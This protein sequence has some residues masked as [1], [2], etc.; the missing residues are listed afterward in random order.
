MVLFRR[1]SV[2]ITIGLLILAFNTVHAKKKA[3]IIAINRYAPTSGWPDTHAHNDLK[4]LEQTFQKQ[5]FSTQSLTNEN[6]TAAGIRRALHQL[7]SEAKAGDIIIVHYSGHGQQ[8]FDTNHDE[9]DG[10]D[11][12]IV[13]YDA[14][15]KV[16]FGNYKGEKHI[17]DDEIGSW[18]DQLKL[19]LSKTGQLFILLD[20][21]YAGT[22]TRAGT[23]SIARSG[24]PILPPGVSASPKPKS[25]FLSSGGI[26]STR[27]THKN[28]ADFVLFT[29]AEAVQQ[30]YEILAPD[31]QTYGSL[32]Y[33]LAEAFTRLTP[34]ETYQGL[35]QRTAEAIVRRKRTQTPTCEGDLDAA[36][37]RGEL[38]TTSSTFEIIKTTSERIQQTIRIAAGYLNGIAENTLVTLRSQGARGN[39]TP[40]VTQ[41]RVTRVD[42]YTAEIE[43]NK[44][45]ASDSISALEVI[46]AV[47]I[48]EG[49]N[50]NVFLDPDGRPHEV[51]RELVKQPSVVFTAKKEK[52]SLILNT[53]DGYVKFIHPN[54][55][56]T[57]DSLALT[58]TLRCEQILDKIFKFRHAHFLRGLEA[59][60]S[61]IG[62]AYSIR[63]TDQ[64]GENTLPVTTIRAPGKARLR[65]QNTSKVPAFVTVLDIQPN[66]IV[67][68]L[69][70]NPSKGLPSIKLAPG[71]MREFSI[72]ISPPYGIETFKIILTSSSLPLAPTVSRSTDQPIGHPLQE[73]LDASQSRDAN[74]TWPETSIYSL[75][76][77]IQPPL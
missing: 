43:L 14:P 45:L 52:A 46:P 50:F 16:E 21:C 19:R 49:N 48:W 55:Y 53:T 68:Q 73:L 8:L 20:C 6:A 34:S 27:S 57:M 5:Q 39:A 33:A 63:S 32:S 62:A 25:A 65:I 60:S 59:R 38:I 58:T 56:E 15:K 70:P 47:Q 42:I 31:G 17:L 67:N 61:Q 4:L 40:T 37:F 74:S 24:E 7:Y 12:A 51:I 10:L 29:G 13:P 22:G 30:S 18:V 64:T 11:E 1:E 75:F 66:A 77:H 9:P 76:F 69:L 23:P 3:L 26:S 2:W 44:A 72:N 71:E 28:T 41:G 36:L 54:S 35:F